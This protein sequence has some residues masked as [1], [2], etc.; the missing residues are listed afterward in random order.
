MTASSLDGKESPL[1]ARLLATTNALNE[2]ENSVKSG[3]LDARVL[4]ELLNA[5]EHIRY[6]CLGRSG[7][8]W[9]PGAFR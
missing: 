9:S 1:A 6:I 2:L 5:I 4:G 7:L 3:D 8:V